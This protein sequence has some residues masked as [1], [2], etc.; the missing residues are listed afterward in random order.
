VAA[1]IPRL[2]PVMSR[3]GGLCIKGERTIICGYTGIVRLLTGPAGSGKSSQ[4]LDE[5]REVLRAGATQVRLLV[6]TAT[7]AQHLQNRL[8]RE[9]F[10]LRR[11]LVQ[12]LSAFVRELTPDLKDAPDAVLYLIVEQAAK[13]VARPEFA[14]VVELPGFSASLK[15]V[16]DEFVSAGCDIER[17]SQSLPDAPLAPAFVVV[18]REMEREL[19]RRG[20]VTR[21]ERLARASE[22]AAAKGLTAVWMDGFHVLT[23]PELSM[24]QSLGRHARLT[25]AMGDDDL[26]EAMR[27]RLTWLGFAE[28]RARGV[29]AT[30]VRALVKA[31][32]IEREAE[33]IARRILAQSV[34]GRPFREIG[35]IV[36]AADTYVPLL[37][38]TLERF[39]IPARFYFDEDLERH[40]VV[41]FLAGTVEAM[42]AG[43][44]HAATL[45]AL[46]LSPRFAESAAM[47]RFDFAV[48]GQIPKTGLAAIKALAT[49]E[50]LIRMID[51]LSAIEQWGNL[52][53]APQDWARRFAGLRALFRPA[54]PRDGASHEL[55]LEWRSQAEA[56]DAFEEA[57]EEAAQAL[58]GAGEIGIQAFWRTMKSVLRLKPLRPSDQRRNVVAVLSAHEARQW[59]LPVVFICGMVEKQFPRFQQQDPFFPD[60]ARCRLNEA[61]IRV[62][63]VAEFER[64]ERALFDSAITRATLLTTLSYPEFDSR[65][66]RNLPSLYLE[67][68]LVAPEA[69]RPVRP[70]ARRQPPVRG[71]V[72]IRDAAL[73]EYLQQRIAAF[74]PT[75][76]EGFLQ[77]PFQYFAMRTLRMRTAPE[78]PEERL[79]FLAMGEIVHEVLKEWWGSPQD[80][81]EIFERVFADYLKA[82]HIPPGYHT[83][84]KRNGML[85]DLLRFA[86]QDT[87]PRSAFTSAM[88]R[89]FEFE[90]AP[91]VAMRGRIDR[92]D[93]AT[94]GQAYVIDYKYS[95]AAN[96]KEKLENGSLLQAPLYLIAAEE[97]YRV[98]PA[99]V[100]YV[101]LRGGL[102]YAGWADSP[103]MEAL[104]MPERWLETTR[105]RVLGIVEE[106]RGGRIAVAPADP[107]KCHWCDARDVCRV[108]QS[109][110]V[111]EVE[112]A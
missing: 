25:L 33:E 98:K 40:P 70:E 42:L 50:R 93:T 8:A 1:P 26:T 81:A 105:E 13:R 10:V 66:E 32:S 112:P 15:R 65:G 20:L 21:A 38:T 54:R 31:A 80:I 37:R 73:L 102:E 103:F 108:E 74:S 78:R 24:V 27:A 84:R 92:I 91:G 107:D 30:G 63:T 39:G 16:I 41:R 23:D 48:R 90:L 95:R 35:I 72:E 104:Q 71:P 67:D 7:L 46:R 77:C 94:E 56:L 34:A 36:R 89:E 3:T 97:V 100:F 60:A 47:D 76:L 51:D 75:S 64:E 99:G 4:I 69:A 18:Y 88:E 9:G 2:P 111:A 45:A 62:R 49:D 106:I 59:V 85:D 86:G 87:W 58:N 110:T 12:T 22:R 83:E 57:A 82:K 28:E 109:E 96:V 6:P 101:G 68:L 5:F 55:A 52:A 14:S 79:S 53:L 29:R 61:G 44:D 17:L 11:G 43:W 19:A